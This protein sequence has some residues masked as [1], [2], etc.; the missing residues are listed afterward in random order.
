MDA[1][2]EFLMTVAPFSELDRHAVAEVVAQCKR[3]AFDAG[4]PL[5]EFSP[6]GQ[7]GLF[8]IQAGQVALSRVAGDVLETRGRGE[9]FGH[10]IAFEADGPDGYLATAE[11]LGN[12]LHLNAAN[13]NALVQKHAVVAD[14]LSHRPGDRLRGMAQRDTGTL[15]DVSLRPPVTASPSLSIQ[16]CAALMA[17]HQV[18]SLPIVDGEQ[19]VGIVTDRDLRSRVLAAGLAP[20]QAITQVMTAAPKSVGSDA[21]IDDAL[22]VMLEAGIH[23]LPVVDDRHQLVGVVSAGDLLRSQ[24]PHPLRL[25]RDIQR[26]DSA[27][28]VAR[29]SHQAPGVLAA[30]SHQGS[31]VIEVGRIASMLTDAATRR[32]LQLAETDL[33]PAPMAWSWLA[34]GSQARME[35]GL[36][37]DQDNGLLLAEPPDAE[38]AAY[39]LQLATRVCDG[40]NDCGYVYCSGDV[41]AMKRWRM[42]YSEWSRVFDQWMREPDPQSIMNCSIFFDQRCVAGDAELAKRLQQRV[43]KQAQ[44]SRI[45][46]RFLAA[47]SMKHTPPLG[48]FRRFLQEERE[49]EG[50]GINLKKRGV[51]PIVDLARVRALEGGL[52]E[53]HTEE[54]IRAA[55]EAGVMNADDADD[56]IHALRFI[57]NIRLKHQVRCHEQGQPPNHLVDPDTLSGLHQRYLRSAFGIV[58]Q[59]HK[60]L[61]LRY[62]I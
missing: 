47:E 19:L 29:L 26:A 1:D 11:T 8:I 59:A 52:S 54:R 31:E 17:K 15:M 24:A 60:A 18:S 10:C 58:R 57:G 55:A 3:H 51:L 16:A 42:A 50:K 21:R 41:M 25:V 37:T 53:V 39:F 12:A 23:H 13:L 14:F 28:E 32:L 49:G 5:G 44:D 45:F 4:E 62:Q 40:L 27:A 2:I 38:Q 20:D 36:V 43:L 46:L 61:A 6:P 33:G 9:L 30:L 35:Q 56:L 48:L 22:L 7:D 34:F